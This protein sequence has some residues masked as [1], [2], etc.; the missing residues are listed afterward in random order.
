M[1]TEAVTGAAQGAAAGA[2]AGSV[3]PV[4]GTA[5][6]AV[7]GGV[8]GLVSGI[9]AGKAKASKKKANQIRAKVAERDAAIQR[10]DLIRSIRVQRAQTVAAGTSEGVISSAVAGAAGSIG[11]QGTGAID[12]F[13]SQYNLNGQ[14]NKYDAKSQQYSGYAAAGQTLI[15]SMGGLASAGMSVAGMFRQGAKP[16]QITGAAAQPYYQYPTGAAAT[17]R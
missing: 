1:S 13:A 4:I 7:V 15:G 16:V 10:R 11:A 9:F 5:I 17:K 8:L 2:V 3:V 6:G 12:F 14:A